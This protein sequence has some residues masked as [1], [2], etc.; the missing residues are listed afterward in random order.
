MNFPI[1]IFSL[2]VA[3]LG[4]ILIYPGQVEAQSAIDNRVVQLINSERQKQNLTPLNFSSKLYQSAKTHNELMNNCANLYGKADCFKHQ[5]TQMGELPLMDRI[6][7]AG[8]NP[9][10]VGEIIGWG[11]KTPE[12]MVKGWM[13]SSGHRGNILTTERVDVGCNFLDAGA[14]DYRKMWW[15]C[16]FGKS[17]TTST[18][19]PVPSPTI[20]PRPTSSVSPSISP[21]PSPK[22]T[23]NP[24][25]TSS[26]TA[27]QVVVSK[28]WWCSLFP[29]ISSCNI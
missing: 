19:T 25:P 20:S 17:F 14:G 10:S 8:Y 12:E 4:I 11:Y 5:V 28:P 23:V 18:A 24:T 3:F 26:P 15:T 21:T 13:G 7:A 16:D 9:K 6:K 27:T 29:M 1:K 2:F 22:S